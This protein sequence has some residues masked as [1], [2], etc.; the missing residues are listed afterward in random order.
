MNPAPPVTSNIDAVKPVGVW[1]GVAPTA[2]PLP[3]SGADNW[4]NP[5]TGHLDRPGHKAIAAYDA[6]DKVNLNSYYL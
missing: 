1:I 3:H 4:G 5:E 2:A 6:S